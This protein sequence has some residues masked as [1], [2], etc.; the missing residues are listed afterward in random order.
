MKV[1]HQPLTDA[2]RW[3]WLIRIREHA[4]DICRGLDPIAPKPANPLPPTLSRPPAPPRPPPSHVAE[5]IQ[6]EPHERPTQ[7][8]SGPTE[9]CSVTTAP[10]PP[11][12]KTSAGAVVTCSA[13]KSKYRDEFRIASLP[14]HTA[15]R[16]RLSVYFIYLSLDEAELRRR[17]A[18]RKNHYM[19]EAMV[20]SQLASL[21]R[22][23]EVEIGED[24]VLV[25][26]RGD[27][28]E[29]MRLV[30]DGVRAKLEK[31]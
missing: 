28:G 31:E 25:D 6:P 19:T 24:V 5:P 7:P 29:V 15:R 1:L 9:A 17:V 18:A 2:D 13:L 3:D 8:T 27:E 10:Q 21:E 14:T 22:P 23:S 26:A 12:F 11:D 4:L 16:F 20:A 30:M